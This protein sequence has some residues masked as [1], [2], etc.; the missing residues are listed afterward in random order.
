MTILPQQ[1]LDEMKEIL[2]EEYDDFIKSYDE[3][4]TTGLR[5]NT[6]KISKEDLL[7][8]NLYNL[9]QI[10]WAKEGFYYNEEVDRPGKSPL[11]EAGAYY[12]QEPSAMSVVPK[13]DVQEDEKILDMCAAPGGKSTYILSKLNNT[14]L[15]VSNEINPTRIRALGENL[16]RFGAKNCIITNTDSNNLRK[17]F[18]G[19]FDKIVIDAPC[20]GQGMFRKDEVA[21]TDWSYA[22][23]LECQS[24]QREIIRDGYEMLTN[25]G[26]LV[27]STCTFAKEENED[28]INEF[29][30]E[31]PNAKLI[32]MERLWPHKVKGEGHFVAKIQK[33]EEEDCNVKQIKIKRIDKEI[34]DYKDFEKKFLNISLENKFEI[35]GENLYL[36]PEESPD[37]KKIK[38]L[39][40]GLHVGTLKKN[41][42][43][44]SHALSHYLKMEDAKYIENL[45]VNDE[46]ILQYLRGNTINTGNSRGWVLVCV[47]GIPIGWGKESNGVLK[48]HYPKGLR[49]NY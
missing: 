25:G 45:K 17:V 35:R 40:Y 23:V 11:H 12:L 22:K 34:K 7:N 13:L 1:F 43:E 3:P 48:N 47:E 26:T 10:P 16:E 9:D 29:I 8:L 15:L 42:F 33:L 31:Y 4:K 38:L 19:Y 5:V 24:I 39:R 21:I 18:T 32:I 36:L 46:Q 41:R 2:N 27:Y 44:P 49:I 37:T 20:S 28:V 30:S 6:L 14:G